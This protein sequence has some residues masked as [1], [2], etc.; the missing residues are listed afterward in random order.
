MR[1]AQNFGSNILGY[2]QDRQLSFNWF[3]QH[4][5]LGIELWS[6]KE[7]LWRKLL[8][9]H[10]RNVLASSLMKSLDWNVMRNLVAPATYRYCLVLVLSFSVNYFMMPCISSSLT[11]FEC[12]ASSSSLSWFPFACSS[13]S[14]LGS[15]INVSVSYP[16]VSEL[17]LY[18]VCRCF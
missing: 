5:E 18:Y 10:R 14:L 16:M 11:S 7:T 12:S 2:L 13:C 6:W 15:L 8:V 1:C 17:L 9:V 3:C 4:G